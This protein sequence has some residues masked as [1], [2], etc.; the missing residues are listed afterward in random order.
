MFFSKKSFIRQYLITFI[1]FLNFQIHF[2]DGY[3]IQRSLYLCFTPWKCDDWG[4][5]IHVLDE[6]LQKPFYFLRNQ[7]LVAE[8]HENI[9]GKN[10][11]S[12][13][14]FVLKKKKRNIINHFRKLVEVVIDVTDQAIMDLKPFLHHVL[15]QIPILSIQVTI[16]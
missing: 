16:K 13:L 10:Q 6:F 7:M 14:Y 12:F 9:Y 1:F 11:R 8:I 2:Q 15:R 3:G 5:D 4:K